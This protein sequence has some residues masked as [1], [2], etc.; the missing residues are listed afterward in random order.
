MNRAVIYYHD[1]NL[2]EGAV[3]AKETS[4]SEEGR[5]SRAKLELL[6]GQPVFNFGCACIPGLS[7]PPPPGID[8][9]NP[10]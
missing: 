5:N 1:R 6:F 10:L 2:I 4:F 9:G 7:F 8:T 3:F